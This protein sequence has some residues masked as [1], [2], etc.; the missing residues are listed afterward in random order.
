[1]ARSA[2]SGIVPWPVCIFMLVQFSF[3]PYTEEV[4][5][6]I[7]DN[8]FFCP[9]EYSPPVIEGGGEEVNGAAVFYFASGTKFVDG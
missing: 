2:G 7:Q 6:K 5:E 9:H 8:L 1:M 3:L 4:K